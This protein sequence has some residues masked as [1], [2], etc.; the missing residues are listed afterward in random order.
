MQDSVLETS[1]V[2]DY[3]IEIT[4]EKFWNLYAKFGFKVEIC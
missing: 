1:L 2:L 3:M 4:A